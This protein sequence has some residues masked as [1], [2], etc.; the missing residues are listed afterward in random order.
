M[1]LHVFFGVSAL[2]RVLFLFGAVIVLHNL[3]VVFFFVLLGRVLR[4]LVL[5]LSFVV[6]LRRLFSLLLVV[7]L[8]VRVW[9]PG[10][11]PFLFFFLQASS[12]PP[13]RL[14]TSSSATHPFSST[15]FRVGKYFRQSESRSWRGCITG[16][17]GV[18]CKLRLAERNRIPS[19]VKPRV[20]A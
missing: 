13:S 2:V 19:L 14:T 7:F 16:L 17:W 12:I 9:L 11:F 1:S 6:F 4:L 10:V 8:V 3:R 15:C 5:L 18:A 20:T